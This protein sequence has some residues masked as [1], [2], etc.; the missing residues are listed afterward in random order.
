M[1][2]HSLL[3]LLLPIATAELC[4][5]PQYEYYVCQNNTLSC[6]SDQKCSYVEQCL[7]VASLM[8]RNAIPAHRLRQAVCGY[9]QTR[10]KICC[11]IDDYSEQPTYVNSDAS[12]PTQS[13]SNVQCGRSLIRDNVN[14]LGS[15]PFVARIGFINTVTGET[16]Y[17][18]NGVI[19]NERT[20]LTTATCALAKSDRYK[21]CSVLIG[22]YNTESDPDCDKLFCGHQATSH[23]VSYVIKHPDYDVASFSNNVALLRLKK[24]IEYTATAQP[25]CFIPEDRYVSLGSTCTVVGWGKLSGQKAQPTTQQSLQLRLVPKQQC[26]DY[27]SQGLSVELCAKGSCEPCTGYSGSPLLYKYADM[28]F[29]VGILSYGSSCDSSTVSPSAFVNVQRYTRWILENC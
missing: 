10:V 15:Y 22:E 24:A 3:L 4:E 2:C 23:D 17:S 14:A 5:H 12:Y 18:C 6:P 29:L 7:A 11:S 26:S 1:H 8:E 21:L 19:V 28:Y 13:S 25:I 20:V 16:K 9:D 27:L